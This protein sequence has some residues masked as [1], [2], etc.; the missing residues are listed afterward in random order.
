[1]SSTN[2]TIA[3]LTVAAA[4]LAGGCSTPSVTVSTPEPIVALG[5][6]ETPV[7]FRFGAGDALGQSMFV[8]YVATLRQE[9]DGVYATAEDER[10]GF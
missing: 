5:V 8:Y 7:P 2:S 3:T 4:L 9:Q 10:A 1:M 6:V